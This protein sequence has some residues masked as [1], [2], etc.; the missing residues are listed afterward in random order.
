[1]ELFRSLDK[2]CRELEP[3]KVA[4]RYRAKSINY[5]HGNNI[6]CCVHLRKSGLRIWLKL[7]YSDLDNPPEYVRDVSHI[8]H[9]GAGE[10]EL[11]VDKFEKL[12]T[13]ETLIRQ[14]FDAN[15]PK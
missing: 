2:F 14:S 6:F 13:A 4:R 8:G 12:R 5:S 9:W 3:T 11:A 7:K 15:A 1:M 10:V